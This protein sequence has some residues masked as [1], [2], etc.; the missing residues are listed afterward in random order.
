MRTLL[1]AA[2]LFTALTA[3]PY[4]AAAQI[5]LEDTSP[6]QLIER[7]EKMRSSAAAQRN[8]RAKKAFTAD[9]ERLMDTL[10]S[11]PDFAALDDQGRIDI[12]NQ[13]E[14]L[15]AR[16]DGGT[17]KRDRRICKR[18]MRVGSHMGTTVCR[19]QAE[20]D[21]ERESSNDSMRE[22]QSKR[23]GIPSN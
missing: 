12:A 7:V 14:S 10:R 22:I 4:A 21:R 1:L 8:E 15:R 20:I 18:E 3:S 23:P 13:Y 17:A 5:S 2:T 9:L 19:T 6:V 16:A 11:T